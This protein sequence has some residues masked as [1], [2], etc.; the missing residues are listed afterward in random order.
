MRFNR[1]ME[2]L[3][4]WL[5]SLTETS[6]YKRQG[7]LFSRALFLYLIYFSIK[8]LILYN[9]IFSDR[10]WY[11]HISNESFRFWNYD[12]ILIV[13]HSLTPFFIGAL[14]VISI[15]G[16]LQIYP[17]LSAFFSFFVFSN[18][19][20]A[21]A[22]LNTG[23]DF[24]V[25]ALLFY[26]IFF[27]SKNDNQ[28][29]IRISMIENLLGNLSILACRFQVIVLYLTSFIYKLTDEAWISGDAISNTFY[30][31]DYAF[32]WGTQLFS[33]KNIFTIALNYAVLFFQGIFPIA[34]FIPRF[35]KYLMIL[36]ICIH[37]VIAFSMGIWD[38]S[39]VMI[40]VYLLFV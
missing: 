6:V 36:G 1:R 27:N 30:S 3:K 20:N 4:L 9:E 32:H 22:A 12:R 40:L 33:D 26:L 2:R 31:A 34:I 8:C 11:L 15:L 13:N 16:L 7:I 39:L 17:R 29:N 28:S 25:R 37:L 21:I 35:K 18:I 19:I 24:L 38:F 14:L 23:G 5:M 10:G